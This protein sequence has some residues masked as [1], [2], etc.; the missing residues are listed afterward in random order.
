M[1]AQAVKTVTPL[2][3]VTCLTERFLL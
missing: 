1:A 2:E 3:K